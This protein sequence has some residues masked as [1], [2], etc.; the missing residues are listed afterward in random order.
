MRG[1]RERRQRRCEERVGRQALRARRRQ[2]RCRRPRGP[3]TR[4]TAR[5][6]CRSRSVAPASISPPPGRRGEPRFNNGSSERQ[7]E[8]WR[9]LGSQVARS[10]PRPTGGPADRRSPART[11]TRGSI[12]RAGCNARVRVRSTAAP[13]SQAFTPARRSGATFQRRVRVFVPQ[14]RV[15]RQSSKTRLAQRF[16]A[17]TG[18]RFLR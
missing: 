1:A 18:G 8:P 4:H 6:T 17:A 13:Y 7:R 10:D 2:S 3:C 16:R 9:L 5:A 14:S 12:A 11:R 15:G